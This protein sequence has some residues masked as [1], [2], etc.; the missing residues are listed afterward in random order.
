MKDSILHVCGGDPISLIDLHKETAYSPRMWRWSCFKEKFYQR[1]IVFS[2]YVEVILKTSIQN[3]INTS[4]LHVCGGDPIITSTSKIS[5][6]YSPRMWRWS[7]SY[8]KYVHNCLVFSTYVEVI[9]NR[10]W[11]QKNFDR[12]LHVC[13]G[14]PIGSSSGVLR[15]SYSPRMCRWSLSIRKESRLLVVFSTYVE[16]ILGDQSRKLTGIG[17]LHVC[18]GDPEACSEVRLLASY[19]PRMWRWSCLA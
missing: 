14:D 12:I 16:V 10:A 15:S 19:S 9:L 5:A 13:G 4:I 18:G 1:N 8:H 2:T 7:Y 6:S 3:R 11:N 17:I